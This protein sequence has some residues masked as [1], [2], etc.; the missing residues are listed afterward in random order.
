MRKQDKSVEVLGHWSEDRANEW[1]RK[2]GW[3]CGFNYIPA[4]AINTVE[5]WQKGDFDSKTIDKELALAESIGF[6]VLRIF[7][8]FIV[9]EEDPEYMIKILEEFIT[10]TDKHGFKV[11]IVPFD[12]CVF[13]TFGENIPNP[14]LGKQPEPV[15]GVYGTWVPSPGHD[16]VGN[17]GKWYQLKEYLQ[18]IMKQYVKDDR[19]IIWD[20]YN[21]PK[22]YLWPKG[23]NLLLEVIKWAR[24]V[25]PSQPITTSYYFPIW[26]LNTWIRNN[27]DVVSLHNY[28]PKIFFEWNITRLRKQN[29]P[30]I[31]TE[32]L[33]RNLRNS[34]RKILPVMVKY[35]TMAIHW[36]FINGKT[37]THLSWLNSKPGRRPPRKWQHDLF[38]GDLTPY[39]PKEIDLFKKYLKTI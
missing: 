10:I 32:W 26:K 13:P 28:L 3:M 16:N 17:V 25:N 36:G 22:P 27:V 35:N 5:M 14:Y 12:D 37:Q 6:N 24:E 39:D 31:V 1:Y 30:I 38:H 4:T 7:T 34:V 9:W 2:V 29:R 11:I 33:H 15:P 18:E 19:V 21:E 20:L 23:K 8:Q